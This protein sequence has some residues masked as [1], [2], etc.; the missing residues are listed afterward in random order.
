[1]AP[2][3]KQAD[4]LMV[5]TEDFICQTC[6]SNYAISLFALIHAVLDNYIRVDKTQGAEDANMVV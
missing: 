1:M 4:L 5:R 3:N 2:A 6:N